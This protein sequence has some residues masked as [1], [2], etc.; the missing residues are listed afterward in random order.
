MM[1][2]ESYVFNEVDIDVRKDL[3]ANWEKVTDLIEKSDKNL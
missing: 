1:L 2:E 3:C